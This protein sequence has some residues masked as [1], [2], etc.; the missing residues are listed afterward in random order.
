VAPDDADAIFSLS[1]EGISSIVSSDSG[2]H[3]F[4]VMERRP[5]I[6]FD[7]IN[8]VM[9]KGALRGLVDYVYRNLGAKATVILADRLKDIGYKYSTKGGLS[10][11]I[12]AMI[13]PEKKGT[14]LNRADKQVV[15]IGRQYTEGLITQGEK[16]NKVV[17]IWA[18]ATDDVANEMM[19]A[20]KVENIYDSEGNPKLDDSGQPMQA[21]SFNPIYMMA[22]SGA[23]A[24]RTRC[25]SWPVCAD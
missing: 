16:Y 23:G 15:E 20:M 4:Q 19:D 22:D 2:Y 13:I 24:A 11:S 8:K 5:E 18:K 12:D 1:V 10:I 25:A 3:L 17:D 6:P 9:D 21:E 7:I 14:I